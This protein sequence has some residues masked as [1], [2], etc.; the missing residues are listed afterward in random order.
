MTAQHTQKTD[1]HGGE[2]GAGH[3]PTH[4]LSDELLLDYSAGTTDEAVGVLIATHLTLC[5]SCRVRA[6]QLDAV[7]GAMLDD[8]APREVAEDAFT[9]LIARL[10][11]PEAV[12]ASPLQD[13]RQRGMPEMPTNA[14]ESHVLPRVLQRYVGENPAAIAWTPLGLGVE[15]FEL[16]VTGG[17]RAVMLR[18]PAGRAVPQHTHEGN[19]YV[20]VLQGA[21]RDEA[22]RFGR[23]DVEIAVGDVDHRPV[24][25]A[26]AD[27][28][29][30][31]VMDGPLRL[32]SLFG[33]ALNRFVSL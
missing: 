1:M 6:E 2:T 3:L 20:I 21:F 15:Q 23:G 25:D 13:D 14:G 30:L 22:G 5:P 31:A 11:E 4:H 17:A 7:G 10:D 16:P 32:T 29:C 18:V 27:C 33:R 8:L 12:E 26:G 24:A 19:E 9:Q 28:I